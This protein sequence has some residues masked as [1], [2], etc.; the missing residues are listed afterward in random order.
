MVKDYGV[1]VLIGFLR[2]KLE[3]IAA[4]VVLEIVIL[5]DIDDL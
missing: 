5:G 1:F 2:L 4:E 3:T